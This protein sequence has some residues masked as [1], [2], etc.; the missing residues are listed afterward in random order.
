MTSEGVVKLKLVRQVRVDNVD[1]S[2]DDNVDGFD[3]NEKKR[4]SSKSEALDGHSVDRRR[5]CMCRRVQLSTRLGTHSHSQPASSPQHRAI[6]RLQAPK[7]QRCVITDHA[8]YSRWK[9]A[10]YHPDLSCA[11][12]AHTLRSSEPVHLNNLNNLNWVFISFCCFHLFCRDSFSRSSVP[13][14]VTA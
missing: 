8:Y 13:V 5:I 6:E 10:S 14:T 4:A 11:Y 1:D 2:A 9:S 3:G 12:F 7:H